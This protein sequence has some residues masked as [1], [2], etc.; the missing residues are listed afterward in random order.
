MWLV[1]GVVVARLLPALALEAAGLEVIGQVL[2]ILLVLV[3]TPSRLGL[4]GLVALLEQPL[5]G[6]ETR[7]HLTRLQALAEAGVGTL[8]LHRQQV[9]LGAAAVGGQLIQAEVLEP[10]VKVMPVVMVLQIHPRQVVE[11]VVALLLEQMAE[12]QAGMAALVNKARLTHLRMA[13]L[14]LEALLLLDTFPVAA[15]AAVFKG[16]RLRQ[17]QVVLAVG[18]MVVITPME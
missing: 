14:V 18:V 6:Q 1:V 15:A 16:L 7:P 4:V 11:V 3:I 2:G 8:H 17:A 9:G 12:V 13:G 10:Q 5:L